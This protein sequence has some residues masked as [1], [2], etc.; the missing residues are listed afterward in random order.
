MK[1]VLKNSRVTRVIA[2][3]VAIVIL[4]VLDLALTMHYMSTTGMPEANPLARSL[5]E[6]SPGLLIVVKLLLVAIGTGILILLARRASAEFGGWL[7]FLAMVA[8]TIHW[9]GY[10]RADLRGEL[11]R[12]SNGVCP[13]QYTCTWVTR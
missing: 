3:V 2:L 10:V 12:A 1:N 9:S 13:D 7:C 5:V 8:L 4:N 11:F 6:I